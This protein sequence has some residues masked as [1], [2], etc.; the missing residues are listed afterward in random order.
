MRLESLSFEQQLRTLAKRRSSIK[1][2]QSVAQMKKALFTTLRLTLLISFAAVAL[3]ARVVVSRSDVHYWT[4]NYTTGNGPS[5]LFLANIRGQ[6]TWRDLVVAN[7]NDNT[8]SVRLCRDAAF[9]TNSTAYA[10]DL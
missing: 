3:Q 1:N 4:T 7:K 6:K 9:N 2:R 8:V 5:S 10:V